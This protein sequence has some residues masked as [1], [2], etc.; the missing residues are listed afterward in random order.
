MHEGL[1]KPT[2]KQLSNNDLQEVALWR[3]VVYS[4]SEHRLFAI[5]YVSLRMHKMNFPFQVC[6]KNIYSPAIMDKLEVHLLYLLHQQPF[7]FITNNGFQHNI[8][9][10]RVIHLE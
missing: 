1:T 6:L 3:N 7:W 4:L 9:Q 5:M 8:V 2:A 10:L